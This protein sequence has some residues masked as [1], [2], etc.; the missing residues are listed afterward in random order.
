MLSWLF[1]FLLL[2]F[3]LRKFQD[4]ILC[5]PEKS[6][7]ERDR[8]GWWRE[9]KFVPSFSL[10]KLYLNLQRNFANFSRPSLNSS[11]FT[12]SCFRYPADFPGASATDVRDRSLKIT[13]AKK[14]REPIG[15]FSAES[16]IPGIG[17]ENFELSWLHIQGDS[18]LPK[19]TLEADF[20][21]NSWSMFLFYIFL[22]LLSRFYTVFH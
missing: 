7:T 16:Q 3:P 13:A 18:S 17:I 22:F 6:T 21:V 8:R 4:L 1:S 12:W 15:K 10:R 20:S 9:G 11:L 5:F 2:S 19:T 14:K